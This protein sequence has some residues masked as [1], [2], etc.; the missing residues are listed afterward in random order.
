MLHDSFGNGGDL[1]DVVDGVMHLPGRAEAGGGSVEAAQ[2]RRLSGGGSSDEGK[3]ASNAHDVID[4]AAYVALH[5]VADVL[6]RT[7]DLVGDGA[8]VLGDVVSDVVD[9]GV[10]EA[11]PLLRASPLE[12]GRGREGARSLVPTSVAR[13]RVGGRL[14]RRP[15]RYEVSLGRVGAA[16]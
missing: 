11:A 5:V 16:E 15:G 6:D 7:L 9:G 12:A 8:R 14:A 2:R 10:H 1:A 4:G 13:T 3:C